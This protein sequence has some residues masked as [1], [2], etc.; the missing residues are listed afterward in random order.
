MARRNLTLAGRWMEPTSAPNGDQIKLGPARKGGGGANGFLV[1]MLETDVQGE[2][3][4]A[5]GTLVPAAGWALGTL[6][7]A[8]PSCVLEVSLGGDIWGAR[9]W[10]LCLGNLSPW[11]WFLSCSPALTGKAS[12][13]ETRAG[14]L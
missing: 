5:H 2:V 6:V 8:A 10:S 1:M 13:S 11:P 7:S 4:L 14:C 3:G 12:F 9:P